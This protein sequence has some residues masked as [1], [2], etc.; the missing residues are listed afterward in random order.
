MEKYIFDG[1]L[2]LISL[3]IIIYSAK[4]GF[5]ATVLS[6][7]SFVG[8]TI[9]AKKVSVIASEFI[10]SSFLRAK[11]TDTIT[12]HLDN[13]SSVDEKKN[14]M[15][16]F[17]PQWMLRISEASGLDLKKLSDNVLNS[18]AEDEVF[19]EN[20]V[21][22]FAYP[23]IKEVSIVILFVVIFILLFVLFVYVSKLLSKITKKIPIIGKANTFFGIILGVLKSVTLIFVICAF[24]NI[25]AFLFEVEELKVL[26]SDS[27]IF[28]YINNIFI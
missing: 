24:F 22:T 26:L 13:F 5:V 21:D 14:A 27:I 18:G 3:I 28:N 17:F 12:N 7:V 10:Y 9:F 8:A 4:K 11:I 23:I 16:S 20:F 15:V 25:S 19:V 6:A 2:L 1:F